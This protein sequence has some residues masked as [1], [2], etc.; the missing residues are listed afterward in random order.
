M[1]LIV[2]AVLLGLA[3][4]AFGAATGQVLDP[5]GAPVS[6]A[7]ICAFVEGTPSQ[8]VNADAQ[9]IYRMENPG[10]QTLLV[11]SSGFV[12]TMVMAAPLNAPVTLKRAAI[13]RVNVIDAADGTPLSKGKVTINTPSGF[14]IGDF[15]PFNRAGVRISTLTPGPV[16]VRAEADGYQPGG[17]MAVELVSGSERVVTVPMTKSSGPSP[18]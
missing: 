1:K 8:C 17:P 9:G 2:L 12:P 3:G 4:P 16:F 7:Q 14:R 15:V 5:D 13:L 10:R 11:R 18:R 6:G